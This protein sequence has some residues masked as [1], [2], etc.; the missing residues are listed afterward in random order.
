M[1]GSQQQ[2]EQGPSKE[3]PPRARV[4][5]V[6]ND[7]FRP[8]TTQEH[9]DQRAIQEH[10]QQGNQ[11]EQEELVKTV[12]GHDQRAKVFKTTS[13]SPIAL[14]WEPNAYKRTVESS[15]SLIGRTSPLFDFL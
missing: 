5:S 3:T 4:Q 2:S 11:C 10:K 1:C 12:Q 6:K 13:R 15:A 14:V 8:L 9:L 7:L